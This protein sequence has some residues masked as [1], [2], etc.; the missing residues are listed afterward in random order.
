MTG[1]AGYEAQTQFRQEGTAGRPG[2]MLTVATKAA[3]QQ[4]IERQMQQMSLELQVQVLMTGCL[5][6]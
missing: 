6:P 5:Y 2:R 1:H 3:A 4:E